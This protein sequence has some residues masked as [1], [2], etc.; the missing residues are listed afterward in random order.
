[1]GLLRYALCSLRYAATKDYNFNGI[2]Y[3]NKVYRHIY[4]LRSE[5]IDGGRQQ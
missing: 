5:V 2:Q 3:I 1:M 4:N